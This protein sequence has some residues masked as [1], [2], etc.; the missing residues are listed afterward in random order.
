[1]VSGS[2]VGRVG[3]VPMETSPPPP[4]AVRSR[5]VTSPATAFMRVNIRARRA[6]HLFAIIQDGAGLKQG[7]EPPTYSTTCGAIRAPQRGGTSGRTFSEDP[8]EISRP[9]IEWRKR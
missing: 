3:R 1:M 7:R 6:H 5:A 2:M 8:H 9:S 4:Q